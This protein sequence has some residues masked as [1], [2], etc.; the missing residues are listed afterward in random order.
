MPTVRG[1]PEMSQRTLRPLSHL[2]TTSSE[3][4]GGHSTNRHSVDRSPRVSDR[5]SPRAHTAEKKALANSPLQ[6]KR[7]S[8]ISNL[9]SQ[10]GQ[11][12]DEVKKLKEQLTYAQSAKK[13]PTM[14]SEET[15]KRI[16]TDRP[17]TLDVGQEPVSP[18]ADFPAS[19]NTPPEKEKPC[20]MNLEDEMPSE[21]ILDLQVIG[22]SSGSHGF[23]TESSISEV[24]NMLH[25]SSGC[26]ES[27]GS[28]EIMELKAKLLRQEQDLIRLS[29]ENED[30]KLQLLEVE[31]LRAK[32]EET[33]EQV[34][35]LTEELEESKQRTTQA[36]EQLEVTIQSK[37][38]LEAEMKR[39]RVQAEQ[40]R[41]A[42]EAATAML[43][44][45]DNYVGSDINGRCG[46]K[47]LPHGLEDSGYMGSDS[48]MTDSMEDVYAGK[49][50]GGAGIK[51]FGEFWKKK[52]PK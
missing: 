3:P 46:N 24:S 12:Q 29:R 45:V 49:R 27:M 42:A 41:K 52:G 31:E 34:K 33:A 44:S 26:T 51:R 40:W 14:E 43:T 23:K 13:E 28:A 25:K 17:S 36:T 6:K 48:P 21:E 39:M 47:H 30:L 5:R 1:G 11:A 38:E 32:E 18:M 7:N 8:R 10:L 9:E 35:R 4:D 15:K 22:N 20:A 2:K 50:K 16:S 37:S 19:P